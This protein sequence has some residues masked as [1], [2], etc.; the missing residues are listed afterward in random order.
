MF[1]VVDV[2]GQQLKVSPSEK[3]F[4]PR[5]SEEIGSTVKFDHVLLLADDNNIKVGTPFVK[6][7]SVQGKI[8]EHVKDEKVIVFKKKK[9]KG[10][11][12]R[13]GHRQQ[14]T[15]IEITNIG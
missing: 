13:R 11:R 12:L 9:R 14:Y 15:E 1:A 8:L 5:L 4:V 7:I 3:I 6:G 2:A 10:Y